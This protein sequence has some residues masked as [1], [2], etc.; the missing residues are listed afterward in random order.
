MSWEKDW[1][2]RVEYKVLKGKQGVRNAYDLMAKYYDS[3][4]FLFWTRRIER[5]EERI[6]DSLLIG[7]HGIC[8]DVGCGTGRYS[9]RIVERGCE[10]IAVDLSVKMLGKLRKKACGRGLLNRISMIVAD[11]E[12]LPFRDEVF[13][14]LICT[15]AFDHFIKPEE[16]V[17][18]FSRVLKRGAICILSTFN[19]R[20]LGEF[21]R[22][23]G[24]GHR[25]PFKTEDSPPILVYEVGHTVL[26]IEEIFSKYA[27]N[28]VKI[29]G[30]CY[31]H[32]LPNKLA[33]YYPLSLDS[34]FNLFRRLIKYA[35]IH[36]ILMKK[37]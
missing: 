28:T 2:G 4:R 21:Q 15:L 35:E 17:S 11:A 10:V 3:S 20:T 8:I 1:F 27:F 36:V 30:C 7:L 9:L 18:E 37:V 13:N 26:E 22:R 33:Q 23:Y 14:S 5:G 25:A 32:L 29:R 31:W 24:L 12:S 19:S 6:L 16:A 34:I